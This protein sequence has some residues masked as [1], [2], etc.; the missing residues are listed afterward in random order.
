MKTRIISTIASVI[1]F[2]FFAAAQDDVTTNLDN[3]GSN[4]NSGDLE[5]TRFE[6]QAALN[7]VNRA[8]G[9]AILDIMPETLGGMEIVPES[10]NVMGTNNAFA[11]LTVNR[12]YKSETRDASFSI[13]SDS[14]IL[15][16]VS[17]LLNM[18]VFLAADENQKR[19][20]LDGY[21]ALM[22]REENSDGE[23]SY[24]FQLPFGNS[25]MNFDCTGVSV[26]DEFMSIAESIP[27]KEIIDIAQ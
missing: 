17:S 2:V 4:Y 20:K 19:I 3:A 1:L 26:E 11:G 9:E 12:D 15:A 13:L 14:P 24:S 25:L 6:L 8:I 23:V 7:G 5:N 22:T 16:S 27:V 21:K 18:S 10:D